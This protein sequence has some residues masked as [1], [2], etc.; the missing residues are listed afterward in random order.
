MAD[1]KSLATVST[2]WAYLVLL[3]FFFLFPSCEDTFN[4]LVP[5]LAA[6]FRAT[7]LLPTQAMLGPQG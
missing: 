2:L 4:D 6:L 1:K 3:S 5:L 7:M